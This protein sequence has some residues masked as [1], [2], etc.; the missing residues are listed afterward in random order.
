MRAFILACVVVVA[1]GWLETAQAQARRKITLAYG[2]ERPSRMSAIC[3]PMFAKS[4]ENQQAKNCLSD[5]CID[6]GF[7]L[8][9]SSIFGPGMECMCYF[10]MTKIFYLIIAVL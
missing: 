10:K 2:E 7:Y 1:P 8:A 6:T 9:S 4:C 5:F 3:R